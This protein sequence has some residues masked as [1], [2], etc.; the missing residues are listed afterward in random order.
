MENMISE[1]NA[2]EVDE[3]MADEL[4]LI[5]PEAEQEFSDCG[6]GDGDE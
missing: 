4:H 6:K 2:R 5:S 3:L 1:M